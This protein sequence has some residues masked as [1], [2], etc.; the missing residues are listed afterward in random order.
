MNELLIVYF[1][2]GIC[3]IFVAGFMQNNCKHPH[4]AIVIGSVIQGLIWP[5]IVV[6]NLLAKIQK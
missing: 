1:F 6:T 2:V 4:Y 3:Q 5:F